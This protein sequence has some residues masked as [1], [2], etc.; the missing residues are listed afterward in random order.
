MA[1]TSNLTSIENF[2][3]GATFSNYGGGSGASDNTDIFIEGTQSGG[4][5]ADN[6][7]DGGFGVTF[8]AI[9]LSAASQHV[10]VWLF[11]TQWA[12]VTQVQ[13]RISSGNDDDHELPTGE[14]PPLGGFIPVWV[15]VSRAPEVGGTANE[16]S[17]SEIGV[18]LDIGNVGGNAQNLILDE[19]MHGTSGLLW[20]GLGGAISD[21]RTYENTNN[22]GNLVALNGV[23]FCYS[24]LEI[25]SATATTFT[26]SGFTLIFPDQSLVASTFMGVTIDLQNASTDI[27]LS[28]ATIQSANVGGAG[29]RPDLLVTGT[30]GAFDTSTLNML[31]MRLIQLTSAC[32]INSGIIDTLELTQASSEILNATLNCRA[33][34]GVAICDDPTFGTTGIHDCNI[35]QVDSGHAFEITSTGTYNFSGLVFSGFGADGTNSAAVYNNSGGAITINITDGGSTPTVRNGTGASTT[36]NNTVAVKITVRDANTG[37]VIQGAR[38]RVI[39]DTGGPLTV[40]TVILSGLTDVNGVIEDTGFNFISNQPVEGVSRKGTATPFYR[41]FPISGTITANGLDQTVFMILDE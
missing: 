11:V 4:R 23:D 15:D 36:I 10:K 40:G 28:D 41:S 32:T 14:F 16:A 20:D 27:D 17:I 7:N 39:A 12:S 33:A 38:V 18:L 29:K 37:L 24:R 22:E 9:D 13:I 8:T 31:G 35:V 30:S 2:N 6:V 19:I 3:V 26:D 1:V 5:R 34:S 21:F 25:G